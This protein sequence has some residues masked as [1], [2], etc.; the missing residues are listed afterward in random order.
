VRIF[1][2]QFS[3]LF[4]IFLL[5]VKITLFS[6]LQFAFQFFVKSLILQFFFS[7]F[8]ISETFNF[9]TDCLTQG[10]RKLIAWRIFTLNF[11]VFPIFLILFWIGLLKIEIRLGDTLNHNIIAIWYFL[12]Y[13]SLAFWS[14]ENILWVKRADFGGKNFLSYFLAKRV[15]SQGESD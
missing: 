15:K 8:M 9:I 12:H 6:F 14:G 11:M 5:N 10:Q 4:F 1:Q 7:S 3:R 2:G 13:G